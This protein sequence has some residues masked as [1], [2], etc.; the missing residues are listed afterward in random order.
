MRGFSR[1]SAARPAWIGCCKERLHKHLRP[2]FFRPL[3]IGTAAAIV[4]LH[5]TTFTEGTE[6]MASAD[7]KHSYFSTIEQQRLDASDTE[8]FS[9]VTT[10]LLCIVTAGLLLGVVSV[11]AIMAMS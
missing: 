1:D 8:A 7:L 2:D 9:A 11:L 6:S 3:R 5:R 4:L 10:I